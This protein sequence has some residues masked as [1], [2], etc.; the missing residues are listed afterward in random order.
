[1]VTVTTAASQFWS[2][3]SGL[4]TNFSATFPGKSLAQNLHTGA[5]PVPETYT[6]FT[7]YP[8]NNNTWSLATTGTG[9]RTL[10]V[11]LQL[12]IPVMVISGTYGATAVYSLY[13]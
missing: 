4:A 2:L 3:D 5:P 7:V 10:C 6:P 12:T 13:Y 9:P 11:D 8:D 1:M